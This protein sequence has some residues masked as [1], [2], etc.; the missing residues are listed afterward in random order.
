MSIIKVNFV[1]VKERAHF[2]RRIAREREFAPFDAVIAKQIPG[3]NAQEAEAA[4]QAIRD[5]YAQMQ[6]DIDNAQTYE[7]LKPI[8]APILS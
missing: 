8:I 1:K 7:E 2:Y 6:I 4:R 5:K 3:Q